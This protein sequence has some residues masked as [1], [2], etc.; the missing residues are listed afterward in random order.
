[1]GLLDVTPMALGVETVGDLMT[2]VIPRNTTIPYSTRQVF[3]TAFDNQRSVEIR[4]L[5]GERALFF[6]NIILGT[7]NLDEITISV[8]FKPEIEITYELNSNCILSV[9]ACDNLSG[10]KSNLIIDR[11]KSLSK[12]EIEE[13]LIEAQNFA[14][15]DESEREVITLINFSSPMLKLAKA[16]I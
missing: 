12:E 10:N 11:E 2:S 8:M 1:M 9:T 7:F 14:S 3:T 4:I 15:S 16:A 5:Q 6:D 13:K